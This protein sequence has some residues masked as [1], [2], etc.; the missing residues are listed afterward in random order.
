LFETARTDGRRERSEALAFDALIVLADAPSAT[1]ARTG[2]DT[3]VVV[4][5]DHT[6]LLRGRTEAGEVCELAGGGP[7]PVAVA[8]RLLDDAFV[9]AVVLDGT[10]VLTVSHLGRTIPARLRTA[11]EELYPECCHETC[12]VTHNLE[13]DHNQP[14]EEGGPTAL[15][16]LGR[17]CPYHHWYKHHH[18]LRLEGEGTRKHFVA[19]PRGPPRPPA[20]DS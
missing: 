19:A 1:D 10:D 11:L 20:P 17:L 3:A 8:S 16:N 6:A 9:K 12:N 18:R 5:I 2:A 13:I 15:W 7:V 4:R 14:V